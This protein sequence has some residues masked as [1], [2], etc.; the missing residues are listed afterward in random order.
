MFLRLISLPAGS[1]E[2]PDAKDKEKNN[3]TDIKEISSKLL[4]K[5]C[6]LTMD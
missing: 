4:R 3:R 6:N 2:A 5:F 1:I